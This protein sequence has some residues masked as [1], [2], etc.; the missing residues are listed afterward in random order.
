MLFQ[1]KSKPFSQEIGVFQEKPRLQYLLPWA[2]IDQD[3]GIVHGK[4]H[5]MLAVYEFRG[6]DMESATP[7]DLIQ[8]NAAL[9][10]VIKNL[11]TG[12]VLYFESQRSRSRD[13]DQS[14]IDIPIIQKM[15]NDRK[16]YYAGQK[17][18]E[19]RYYFTVFAEPPQLIKSRITD[20]F[21][22]DAKNKGKGAEMRLYVECVEKF[23]SNAN[24]I[25][26]M[27]RAW[28]PDIKPLGAEETITYLHSTVSDKY[29]PVKINP[30]YYVTD[31]ICDADI[32]GGREMR[33]GEKHMK[34]VTILNFPPMSEPGVFDV[35]DRMDLE[36]RWVSR[37][38]CMSK[39]DAEEELRG[40]RKRWNQQIKGF[41]TQVLEAI[42][43]QK[44]QQTSE[45]A[46]A[47]DLDE[48][49]AYN[50]DD[51]GAALQELGQDYVSYGYYTMTMMVLDRDAQ[52]CSEKANRVLEG[53]NSLGYTGYIETDNAME[54]WWGSIP[55]CYRANIR[56]PIVSSLNF[57][58]M[59]PVTATWPGDKKNDFL[60][61]PVLLYTDTAGYTPFRLSLHVGDVGHTMICGPSGSGKSV[62][63][64]TIEAH[65]L[66]YR[67]ANVFVFDKAMSS[68]AL[69]L[70]VEGNFY[71]IA[72]EGE[73]ELSF[74][75]LAEIH[76]ED[77][78]KWAKEWI[79]AYLQQR[80]VTITPAK[81]NF[82]WKA[83]VSLKEFPVSQRTI[84]TFCEL[85]QDKEIRQALKSLTQEGS[86]GKL[87]DNNKDVSGTGR[88]QVY[89]METLMATPAIVP[90]TL[91]Y[92]FHR[93]EGKL[94][95]AKGPSIIVLDECWLFFDNPIFK[96]KLREY[97]KDM[98]K[99][100]TSIIFATQN[101]SDLANKPE[102]LHTV[103]ENCPNRIYLPNKQA[104][105]VQS[106]ELYKLFNCNERQVELIANMTPK[107]DYYYSSE[108]GNRIFRLAL[109]PIEIPFVTATSKTD[110][111]AINDILNAGDRD[112][113]IE[114]W[115]AYKNAVDEWEDYRRNYIA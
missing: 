70:A 28:L 103:V 78:I 15:E 23:I 97:F 39:P 108:K 102:L 84:S 91:D 12:Y 113:F 82:V 105:T 93:I 49:A 87:F 10:N 104:A 30:S 54:A 31:Y 109:R 73:G 68:R 66:K 86:Y 62:L 27:L 89:E 3:T 5:S 53:I 79:I 7:L 43:K 46:A 4:D 59:A 33:I 16:E 80:N 41:W 96:E 56:R 55:G 98:R 34:I 83:L 114:K 100:N 65:F 57:C 112:R 32:L 69:T 48:T 74:Q 90:A 42:N 45:E 50:R 13:Y 40:Y 60:K 106:K 95:H 2:Y 85:V 107:Q 94:K 110:Q 9:N 17:H 101:L 26:D 22:A 115:L 61:G 6:P 64:N 51:A 38:I 72:S 29:H 71:N 19:T 92:L 75:P 63:L 24:L 37:F 8:Y 99:K 81:D 44:I 52:R 20:A 76:N 14:E 111:Q 77:E 11:P 88:W 21:I 35:F 1:K 58:H 36:Y 47:H 67:D 18:F 25:G